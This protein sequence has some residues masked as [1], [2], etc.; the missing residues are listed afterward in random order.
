MFQLICTHF[1]VEILALGSLASGFWPPLAAPAL[2]LLRPL[3]EAGGGVAAA[4]WG[5]LRSGASGGTE[6]RLRMELREP[7]AIAGTSPLMG[8]RAPE[9]NAS[10]R[11]SAPLCGLPVPRPELR[12]QTQEPLA[13]RPSPSHPD[14]CPPPLRALFTGHG[15]PGLAG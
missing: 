6:G 11:P 4:G 3:R 13:P 2:R 5:A 7:R 14:C 1:Q 12:A 8:I 15:H 9:G 10:R